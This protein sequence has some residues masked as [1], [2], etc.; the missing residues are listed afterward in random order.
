MA[1][2]FDF[3]VYDDRSIRFAIAEPIML[4]DKDVTQ[5]RFRIPKVLNNIDMTSWEWW[6]IFVNAKKVK[7][8]TQ[9]TLTDD[10]DDPDNYSNATYTVGYGFSG[11]VGSVSFSIEALNVSGDS[12]VNEWH[13]KTYTT[14]V[15]DTLQ[16]TRAVIPEPEADAG[17]GLTAEEKSLILELF[18]KAAYAEDDASTAYDRLEALW[19]VITRLVSLSLTH[20]SSSNTSASVENGS[21]Y[22]TTLTADT[23]YTINSVTVTMGGVD[24]TSTAY[25]SGT[26][27]IPSV[28]GN[29]V[30][31]A[32]AV[33]QA[34]SI[35][36][37]YTQ[38]GTVYTT[39]SLDSLKNDLVVTANYAG[40]TSAT[41]PSTDYTLSGTLTEGTSTITVSYAG[42]TT[43][44]NVIATVKG[45]LYHFNDS[46][47]S[48]GEDDFNLVGTGVYDTGLFSKNCYKHFTPTSGTASTDTQ[49]G[50]YAKNLAKVLD[51]GHDFTISCWMA[52]Q[53]N[54]YCHLYDQTIARGN[55]Y[56]S[57]RYF[58]EVTKVNQDWGTLNHGQS[59]NNNAGI[60]IFMGTQSNNIFLAV[61][62]TNSE[63]TAS[64]YV[65]I[66]IPSSV[67]TRD[68]HHYALTRKGDKVRMFFDGGILW[69]ATASESTIYNSEQC[70]ISTNFNTSTNDIQ[71]MPNGE[72]LQDLYIAPFC[73]WESAFD[74]S[75]I[76]Y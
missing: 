21:R 50:L 11:Y 65:G 41:I 17:T 16:G 63:L 10:E 26:I 6:F 39:D 4:E 5:F 51:Y 33:L 45:W 67:D 36:A 2:I 72:K 48:S 69:E 24:I 32:T 53:K 12:I 29:I 9:L 42:L 60:L 73:K 52:T 35:T 71:Q 18:S 15:I 25:S 27:T 58:S 66:Y 37:T 49:Y 14:H 30:I 43:T 74:T 47:L 23:N 64:S 20:V 8:T 38:S 28:T 55:T 59:T 75:A 3:Y 61:R 70:A 68:W 31:T 76:T 22:V 13:T 44:F 7:Y 56:P 40:G 1:D 62:L 19:T 34:Q 57:N 54:G 46:L